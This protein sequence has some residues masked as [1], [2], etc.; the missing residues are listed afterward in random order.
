MVRSRHVGVL[1]VA[2]ALAASM[3]VPASAA[4]DGEAGN[5]LS[6][7]V[8]WAE[9]DGRPTI[10]GVMGEELFDGEILD[11]TLGP[12]STEE[13]FGAVQKNPDNQWQAENI[14]A[15]PG[16]TVNVIDWGDNLE[17]K[18]WKI[19]SPVRVETGLYDNTLDAPMNRYEM[20]YISGQGQTE[21]WGASVTS[22]NPSAKANVLPSEEAMVF[23]AGAR[24]TIQR[25]VDPT[26]ATWDAATH[27]WIGSG[28]VAPEFNSA[29][30][31]KTSDG[32]GSYGAELNVQ[33]KI[34]YG[35]NW[36][37]DGLFNGEYRL[38]F[39]LD[40]PTGS[41]LGSGTSLQGATIL[42]SEEGEEEASLISPRAGSSPNSPNQA[43]VLG[44]QELTYIDVALEGGQ[45]PPPIDEGDGGGTTPPPSGGGTTTPPPATSSP[46]TGEPGGAQAGAGPGEGA[47][48]VEITTPAQLLAQKRQTARIR[49]PKSA[50][51]KVGTMLVLAKKPVK[52][53]AGVT[54]RWRATEASEDNCTVRVRNGKATA[55]MIKAGTC[56]VIAFAPA[57]SPEFLRF[58]ETRT[59][60]VIR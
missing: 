16:H 45:D 59:Y 54:V 50:A 46:A 42:A 4:E 12:D 6:F 52:T 32:P 37:T 49:A 9:A 58:R 60:R 55:E 31:E 48:P 30:H 36:S 17:V 8:I 41:F 56:R 40:G 53:S 5:N 24:L 26:K 47:G 19:G 51:F 1:M 13:C 7:P 18:D 2:S 20:C 44:D 57:P 25:I 43:V 14:D 3:I 22:K 21:K 11:G 28:V 10:P 15:A 35:Y 27:Q 38:T 39:S 34:I 33:G 23:T 29:V